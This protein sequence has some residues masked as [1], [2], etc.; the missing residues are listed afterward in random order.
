MY[1]TLQHAGGIAGG[2]GSGTCRV[3][4]Q[5]RL[6]TG[7]A[8]YSRAGEAVDPGT[9]LLQVTQITTEGAFGCGQLVMGIT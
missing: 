3:G 7:V 4:F 5:V 1:F 8:T 9:V 6:M 2:V